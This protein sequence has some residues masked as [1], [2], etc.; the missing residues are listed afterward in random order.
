[1]QSLRTAGSLSAAHAALRSTGSWRWPVSSIELACE[2]LEG[3]DVVHGQEAIDVRAHGGDARG[4]WLEAFE[5]Q[6]R[7]EPEEL[8]RRAAQA[9]H[10][11]REH[12]GIVPVEA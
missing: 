2:V 1:M 9:R 6:Q 3:R 11:R 5:A 10:L 7:I 4:A 12:F 8:S